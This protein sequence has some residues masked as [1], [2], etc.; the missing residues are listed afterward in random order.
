MRVSNGNDNSNKRRISIRRIRQLGY[1]KLKFPSNIKRTQS[2]EFITRRPEDKVPERG[3]DGAAGYDLFYNDDDDITID[4]GNQQLI[5]LGICM[6]IPVGY[7]G[8][9]ADRSSMASKHRIITHAG[10]IDDD[11]VM[12]CY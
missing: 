5:P 12:F 1:K 3:T 6:A 9:I 10:V 8:R 4:P 2:L 11:Y 7:Y